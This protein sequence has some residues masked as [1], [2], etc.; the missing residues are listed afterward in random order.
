[1]ITADRAIGEVIGD[2]HLACSLHT[3]DGNEQARTTLPTS[4][5]EAKA[6]AEKTRAELISKH[7]SLWESK[8]FA[9]VP[10]ELRIQD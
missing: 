7:R 4:E 6:W 2:F 3:P 10:W 8:G 5:A 1:M 9:S